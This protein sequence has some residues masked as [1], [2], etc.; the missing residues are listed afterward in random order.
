MSEVTDVKALRQRIERWLGDEGFQIW[1]FPD[2]EAYFAYKVARDGGSPLL[3]WQPRDKT[4][5]IQVSSN[6]R[7][8]EDDH[9]KLQ[10]VHEQKRFLLFDFK[11]VLLST[12]C[13]WQF[14]PSPESWRSLR[15]SK[16]IFYDGL[17]KD[18]FFE[19]I[20]AITR[21]VSTIMVTFQW[22]FDITPVV[23]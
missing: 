17:S 15:V 19:T 4:D 20:D 13:N 22:K 23:S 10:T 7:L 9:A 14:I 18:R 6:V 3:I 2:K 12:G 21:A 8:A 11:M 16:T 5:S 1:P